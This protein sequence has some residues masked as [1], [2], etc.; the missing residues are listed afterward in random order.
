MLKSRLWSLLVK[1]KRKSLL[2]LSLLAYRL[3]WCKLAWWPLVSPQLQPWL[4]LVLRLLLALLL[5]LLVLQLLVQQV[6]SLV[7]VSALSVATVL[8]QWVAA[9]VLA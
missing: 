4:Q 5:P 7:A 3:L 6:V 9:V 1:P 2:Q 8:P